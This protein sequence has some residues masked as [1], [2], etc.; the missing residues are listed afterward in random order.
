MTLVRGLPSECGRLDRFRF[1]RPTSPQFLLQRLEQSRNLA[2]CCFRATTVP[3]KTCISGVSMTVST[4]LRQVAKLRILIA[5]DD[6][7]MRALLVRLLSAD[8]EV[9]GDFANGQELLEGATSVEPDV[10]VSDVSMPV[11]SGTQA[12]ETLRAAGHY[13]PF[14]FITASFRATSDLLRGS[15]TALVHKFDIGSELSIA[16][17]MAALGRR[18]ISH[19]AQLL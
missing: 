16:I 10:I 11:M 9:L 3:S 17:R 6:K 8:F 19:T 14:V 5:E 1:R 12:M 18:Y 15:A 13:V 2:V 4:L 7:H